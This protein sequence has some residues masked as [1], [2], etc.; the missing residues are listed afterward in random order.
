MPL[1]FNIPKSVTKS[2]TVGF[3][4]IE[5]LVVVIIVSILASIAAPDWFS[6]LMSRR[7]VATRDEVRQVLEQAQNRAITE[8]RKHVVTFYP[9]E[10]T[11]TVSV[12]STANDGT[13][14][15]LGGE[16]VKPGMLTL[17]AT[18]TTVAFDYNGVVESA[19]ITVT[20]SPTNVGGRQSCV[21][22]LTLLGGLANE[23]GDGCN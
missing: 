7:V 3:T 21:K 17:S 4:L 18:S 13:K 5:V 14:E 9:G 2:T 8:R 20:I 16:S 23:N 11:P 22:V 1:P 15:P 6:Y 19:P 10:P 12:G